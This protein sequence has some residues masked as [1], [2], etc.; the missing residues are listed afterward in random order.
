MNRLVQEASSWRIEQ[1]LK[2]NGADLHFA[3]L[4]EQGCDRN[5]LMLLLTMVDRDDLP[6]RW[7]GFRSRSELKSAMRKLES[8][9]EAVRVIQPNITG[10]RSLSGE[11]PWLAMFPVLPAL[12]HSYHTFIELF[13][14][15]EESHS[16]VARELLVAHVV[17]R[18]GLPFDREVA[19]IIAALPG[20]AGYSIEAHSKW[21][22]RSR[23]VNRCARPE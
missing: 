10:F 7:L 16:D 18:T 12:L 19:G 13:A 21:R 2:S 9:A 20:R 4:I 8:T 3:R 6:P 15:S 5:H 14:N 22:S 1:L 11:W 23:F 17:E